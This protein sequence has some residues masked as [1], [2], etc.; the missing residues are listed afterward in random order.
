M[1]NGLS[2]YIWLTKTKQKER[3]DHLV[4]SHLLVSDCSLGHLYSPSFLENQEMREQNQLALP[5]NFEDK[6]FQKGSSL[7]RESLLFLQPDV[8]TL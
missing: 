8:N 3:S 4:P 6:N 1:T 7:L 5:I 2:V